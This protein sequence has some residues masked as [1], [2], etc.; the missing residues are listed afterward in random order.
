[1]VRKIFSRADQWSAVD[2]FEWTY[3]LMELRRRALAVF[4]DIDFLLVPTAPRPFTVEE[5]NASP[6]ERN[7]EV[8]Y[9][10]YFVNLLDLCAISVPNGFLDNG[11]PSGLTLVAPA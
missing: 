2:V 8:G 4:K 10:S 3:R 11:M 6:I 1:M 7:I 9:Y 5:V